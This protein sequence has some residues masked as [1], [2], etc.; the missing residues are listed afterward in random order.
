MKITT[1]NVK[2]HFRQLLA[3]SWRRF[4]R[5]E[6][7]VAAVEFGIVA[8]PFIALLFAIIETAL[9][10]FSGQVLET[11]VT[12]SAR[13][14]L[15]GQAQSSALDQT[16]FKKA[17]CDR[18][19]GLI[20]CVNNV[21]VDVRK[22]SNFSGISFDPQIDKD[23]KLVNNFVYQPGNASEIVVVRLLYEFPVYM[24][25]WNPSLVTMAGNKRL[26]VATAAF[27]NEPF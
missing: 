25:L 26:I 10:F 5:N 3:R 19:Q 8:L 22:F 6:K 24:Q 17:V 4:S 2:R 18:I 20:D 7:G 23:G 12:D 13:L 1:A 11:A 21:Y 15:T 16:T 27:R 14:I 9:I